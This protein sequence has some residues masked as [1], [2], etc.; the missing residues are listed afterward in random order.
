MNF[1]IR[2]RLGSQKAGTRGYRF[3]MGFIPFVLLGLGWVFLVHGVKIP[4]FFLPPLESL[5]RVLWELFAEAGILKDVLISCCRVFLGFLLA[6][7]LATPLGLLMGYSR[8]AN[9]VLAPMMGFVRYLPVPVF[10]PLTILWFGSG[11]LQKMMIIF[12]G[13]FFQ[14]I[15]MVEDASNSVRREYFE[16]AIMLGAPRRDLIL[17]VL[18]PA[19]LPQIVDSYRVCM[20]WAWTYLVVAE[21][22][23]SSSGIGYYIIKAQRYLLVPQIFA[24]IIIIG[25]LGLS[26]D[27]S[28]AALHRRLFPW[29]ERGRWG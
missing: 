25:F 1:A 15:L 19:A 7:V 10:I 3:L 28:L 2:W 14:L 6:V 18:W 27:L 8:S 21:L 16:S 22:V 29:A 12:V 23:G 11:D 20:G 17:R 24:A 13:V 4:A 9:L 5:P 26:T